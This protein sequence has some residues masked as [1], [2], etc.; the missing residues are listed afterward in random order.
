MNTVPIFSKIEILVI[1][2]N[3]LKKYEYNDAGM[4]ITGDYIVIVEDSRNSDN[5]L[6]SRGIIYDIKTIKEYKTHKL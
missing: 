5:S 6:T 1:E 3:S 4:Y 2:G